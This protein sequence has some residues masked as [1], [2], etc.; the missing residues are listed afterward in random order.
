M[1]V[2]HIYK[3]DTCFLIKFSLWVYREQLGHSVETLGMQDESGWRWPWVR[4]DLRTSIV[5]VCALLLNTP[6]CLLPGSCPDNIFAC[7]TIY[8]VLVTNACG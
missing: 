3:H 7:A 5:V 8:A 6:E 4:Y 1:F 2:C